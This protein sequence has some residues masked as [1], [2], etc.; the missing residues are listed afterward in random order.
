MIIVLYEDWA[1]AEIASGRRC[2]P[3]GGR[4]RPWAHARARLIRQLDGSHTSL[5]PRRVICAECG[6]TQ[7]VLP[8]E[9]LPRRRDSVESIGAALLMAAKGP[10]HRRI[11]AKLNR[12]ESTVRN[13]LRRARRSAGWLREAGLLAATELDVGQGPMPVR[14]TELAETVDALGHAAATAT[15][16]LGL[17]GAP[18]WQIITMV[19]RGQLLASVPDG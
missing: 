17:V 18:P 15:R 14:E 5:R 4:L 19:S 12:P 16:A 11:A 6:R 8:A 9:C 1:L 13:W 2:C 10:G 3:C 7:V